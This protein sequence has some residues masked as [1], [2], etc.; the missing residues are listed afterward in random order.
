[1]E[2]VSHRRDHLE[3]REPVE[4]GVPCANLRESVLLRPHIAAIDNC[5]NI[6]S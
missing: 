6:S 2:R 1:M 4:V 3:K 5:N